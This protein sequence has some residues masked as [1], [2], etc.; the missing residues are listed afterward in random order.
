VRVVVRRKRRRGKMEGKRE[1]RT[2]IQFCNLVS[3]YIHT[4]FS[5]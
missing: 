5:F 1:D 4:V 3:E 2:I